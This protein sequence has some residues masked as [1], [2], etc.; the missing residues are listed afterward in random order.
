MKFRNSKPAATPTKDFS[1]IKFKPQLH[2]STGAK[3]AISRFHTRATQWGKI[4][5]DLSLD[6]VDT[7]TMRF[8][9]RENGTKDNKILCKWDLICNKSSKRRKTEWKWRK[10]RKKIHFIAAGKEYEKL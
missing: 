7:E 4:S 2:L 6:S 10:K 8:N 5:T 1:N 9:K 3:K